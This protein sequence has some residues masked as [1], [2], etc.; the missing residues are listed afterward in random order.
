MVESAEE[1]ADWLRELV[2]TEEQD[3]LPVTHMVAHNHPKFQFQS[4]CPLLTSEVTRYKHGTHK[5]I[6][7]NIQC[8]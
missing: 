6:R 1:L 8:T 5:Y 2:L 4:R 7:Q 3:L